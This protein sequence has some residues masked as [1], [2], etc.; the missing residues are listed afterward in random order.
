MFIFF[1]FIMVQQESLLSN[2]AWLQVLSL[3]HISYE[4]FSEFSVLNSVTSTF[5]A[6]KFSH[7]ILTMLV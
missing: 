2:P 5:F 6:F 3:L 4:H 1:I 7:W